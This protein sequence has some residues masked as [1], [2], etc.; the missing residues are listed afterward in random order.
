MAGK[1]KIKKKK[2]RRREQKQETNPHKAIPKNREVKYF[3]ENTDYI[4]RGQ[5]K[6]K[7]T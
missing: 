4:K 5:W 1:A 3:S 7:S 2:R 6:R